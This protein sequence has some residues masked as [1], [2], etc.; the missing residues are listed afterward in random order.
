MKRRSKPSI[1]STEIDTENKAL[2][3]SDMEAHRGAEVSSDQPLAASVEKMSEGGPLKM[4][5]LMDKVD[6]LWREPFKC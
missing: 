3:S 4:G 1:D 6:H 5:S 2:T